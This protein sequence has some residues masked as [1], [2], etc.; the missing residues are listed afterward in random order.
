MSKVCFTGTCES[1]QL[2]KAPTG[3]RGLDE[4]TQGGLP[5]GRPTLVAGGAGSGKTMLAMEF[6]ARGAAEFGEPG[7]FLAFEETRDDLVQNFRSIGLDLEALVEQKM[8]VIDYLHLDQHEIHEAGDFDLEGLFFRLGLAVDAVGARRVAIDTIEILFSAFEN[9]AVIR[10]ELQR[11][12]RWLKERQLSAVV[13]G[14]RG[15]NTITRYGL[16]EYVADCVILLDTRVQDE[17][18]TRRLRIVKYRGSTH[19]MDEYPFLIDPDGFSVLPI[20]SATLEQ[21]AS[22]ERVSTG[23]DRLDGMLGGGGVFRGSSVLVSGTAGMGKSTIA[24]HIADAA[25]R[26]GERV[27]YFAFEESQ[28]QIARNMRSVGLDLQRWADRGLLAFHAARPTMCGLEVH[29][30]NV[31]RAVEAFCPDLVV[32]DPLS[33]LITIGEQKQV[34]SM[35]TRLID[36]LKSRRITGVFTDLTAADLNLEKTEVGVSSLMD[37]WILLRNLEHNGERNRGLYVIK[38]RGMAHSN[39]IREFVITNDGVRLLDVYTGPGGVLTGASRLAQEARD[40]GEELVRQQ[41]TEAH[42]RALDRKRRALEAQIALL[43]AEFEE[44]EEE[45]LLRSRQDALREEAAVE[46][47]R[48]TALRRHADATEDA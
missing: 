40:R 39:Q 33:N 45:V 19:G 9:H 5:R 43:T 41:E 46:E 18:T 3:I 29:L 21:E 4:I 31:H 36:F 8:L 42:R 2:P 27:L 32:I 17:V 38:S 47:R 28:A 13:T 35:L 7:V 23:I 11:L 30:V 6:L 14:E 48:T 25:C 1:G 26:R 15:E 20:S 24:A 12:F 22:D 10:S 44:A 16:E 34:R 37:T